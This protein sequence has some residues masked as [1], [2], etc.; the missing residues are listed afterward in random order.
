MNCGFS[1]G[2]LHWTP[3]LS[4]CPLSCVA[5]NFPDYTGSML[6]QH[7]SLWEMFRSSA[8]HKNPA[9]PIKFRNAHDL[10]SGCFLSPSLLNTWPTLV[11]INFLRN[12]TRTIKNSFLF[13]WDYELK[14]QVHHKKSFLL[15]TEANREESRAEHSRVRPDAI[16]WA[17]ES[18][19]TRIHQS[20]LWMYLR[21]ALL[22]PS[23]WK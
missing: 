1:F 11:H 22:H 19:G 23:P 5:L 16:Y 14:E 12:W 6:F 8:F 15:E 2:E 17:P 21:V 13:Q 9:W 20:C 7:F 4:A 10:E 18:R 3:S